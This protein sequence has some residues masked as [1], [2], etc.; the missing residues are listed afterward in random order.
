MQPAAPPG[1]PSVMRLA[2]LRIAGLP[3]DA[4]HFR[5][6]G[7][8]SVL[9]RLLDHETELGQGSLALQEALFAAAGESTSRDEL[10]QSPADRGTRYAILRLRRDLHNGRRPAAQDLDAVR[11]VLG[12][13]VLDTLER[14]IAD[15]DLRTE[16]LNAYHVTFRS[17]WSGSWMALA[18][19][20]ARWVVEATPTIMP[21]R[22]VS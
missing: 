10:E 3:F 15:L 17:E 19:S 7:S 11:G 8:A 22:R 9:E 5:A 12:P 2:L 1:D 20:S 14:H 6:S 18:A 21:R 16:L 13:E 4:F